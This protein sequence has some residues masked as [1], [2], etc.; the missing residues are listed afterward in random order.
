MFVVHGRQKAFKEKQARSWSGGTSVCSN[1]HHETREDL[2]KAA[3]LGCR[4]CLAISRVVAS[5]ESYNAGPV[6]FRYGQNVRDREMMIRI[7]PVV[8]L[9]C[10]TWADKILDVRLVKAEGVRPP[11]E[12]A[13]YLRQVEEDMRQGASYKVRGDGFVRREIPSN[14]GHESNAS[15]V[16]QWLDS[17]LNGH[18]DCGTSSKGSTAENSQRWQPKRLIDVTT[19]GNR[20]RLVLREEETVHEPYATLSYCW[21]NDKFFMLDADNIDAFRQGQV[22]MDDLPKS[23]VD[24]I[25]FCRKLGLKYLWINSLCIVQSGPGCETDQNLHATE[26]AAIFSRCQL[27]IAINCSASPH[28]GAF[29]D[30]SP[31]NLDVCYVPWDPYPKQPELDI[32]ST[33][34]NF[35]AIEGEDFS[36][37]LQLGPLASRGQV[38]Q[39]RIL[40]PRIL[41]FGKD[42][43]YWEC[44]NL[45]TNE[46]F[47]INHAGS[48]E[49]RP[50]KPGR[51]KAIP[52]ISPDEFSN[53]SIFEL[54]RRLESDALTDT[55]LALE[56]TREWC[57]IIQE[58]SSLELSFPDKDKLVALAGIAQHFGTLNLRSPDQYHAGLFREDL[59]LGLLWHIRR[60]GYGSAPAPPPVSRSRAPSWSWANANSAVSFP[61]EVTLN[62]SNRNVPSGILECIN[63]LVDCLGVETELVD[64]GNPFGQAHIGRLYLRGWLL[65]VQALEGFYGQK[66]VRYYADDGAGNDGCFMLPV[67]AYRESLY[68]H[69]SLGGL[70]LKPTDTNGVYRR[71]GAYEIIAKVTTSDLPPGMEELEKE[72]L[73]IV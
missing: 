70:I 41:H 6:Y 66:R 25:S 3:E 43:I 37:N 24:A 21:G 38:M 61:S 15:L 47:H 28:D 60:S 62:Y 39:E 65:T 18:H 42:R 17:C 52:L 4:I 8:E 23:F 67:G 30:R 33:Q 46:A 20:V 63:C 31:A 40:S 27:N 64:A 44:S 29:R 5:D 68:K 49:P 14:T 58:Y 51:T 56:R 1:P 54:S 22:S 2:L 11:S 59:P 7:T 48:L 16:R 50:P 55:E 57:R 73:T 35:A 53:P 12:Y 13:S 69:G 71:V 34:W 36:A 26:M 72:S 19:T 32:S 45:K 10:S 9:D